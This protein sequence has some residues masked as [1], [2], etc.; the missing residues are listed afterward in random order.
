MQVLFIARPN[1]HTVRGGDTVQ[2]LETAAALKKLGVQVD[3]H[4]SGEPA[5]YDKYDLIHFFNIIDPEDILGHVQRTHKPFMVSTIYVDYAEYDR[6]HRKDALGF[7]SR[8][9]PYHSIEYIKTLAKFVLKG[10]KVSTWKYF[11]MGNRRSIKHILRRAS[12]ILPN[13]VSEYKR[14]V[15]DFGV[16]PKLYKVV[17][18]AINSGLFMEVPGTARNIV[19]CVGR[20][21][22]RKNQLNLIRACRKLDIPLV[23][24]GNPSPNQKTYYQQCLA[25]G[26]EGVTFIGEIKQEEL[27]T[28][29]NKA[30]VHVLPSWF[31]TTGLSSL[32]AAAMGC[33]IVVADKG[34]VRAYFGDFAYYC[35][36]AE[37]NS[38]AGAIQSAFQQQPDERLKQ[39]VRNEYNWELAAQQTLAAYKEVLKN[40]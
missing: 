25:E 10:E 36:P 40:D 31:E 9:L 29:Y 4:L 32:E 16:T 13:S 21:E 19:L 30:K 3:F 1:L 39:K 20:I 33:Q 35:D 14:V 7:L 24:I 5:T 17:T 34:D 27:L 8:F 28:Y 23:I 11:Y 26:K 37:V 18:N 2:I 38:I 6:L 12:C 22:G 15:A